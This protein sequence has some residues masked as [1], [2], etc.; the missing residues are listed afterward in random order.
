MDE[1][2][3]EQLK[4]PLRRAVRTMSQLRDTCRTVLKRTNGLQDVQMDAKVAS[5]VTRAA[6]H[7]DMQSIH[8]R[9]VAEDLHPHPNPQVQWNTDVPLWPKPRPMHSAGQI[10]SR[11]EARLRRVALDCARTNKPQW[12]PTD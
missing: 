9:I 6:R 8:F 3:Q 11:G 5:A 12:L 4:V 2:P 10:P 7:A 1:F